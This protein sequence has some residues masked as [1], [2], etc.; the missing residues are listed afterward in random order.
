M[1]WALWP[2]T[3]HDDELRVDVRLVRA[4]IDGALP[5]YASLPLSALGASGS[6][7]ALFRWRPRIGR[8]GARSRNAGTSRRWTSIWMPHYRYGNRP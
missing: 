7:N 6:S 3:F 4:L 1:E 8:R 2:K 5:E